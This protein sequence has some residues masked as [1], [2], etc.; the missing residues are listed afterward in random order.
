MCRSIISGLLWLLFLVLMALPS[1]AFSEQ[2]NNVQVE[3][4]VM[5]GEADGQRLLLDVY[6]PAESKK[7]LPAIVLVH[8]GGW[9][10][11]D[12]RDFHDVAMTLSESGYVC[13]SVNYRLVTNAGNKYPAQ[14]DDVQRAVRWIRANADKYGVDPNHIGALGASAGGHLV[15]LLGTMD[16]RINSDPALARYS[17]R[18]TCVVDMFGPV[19]LTVRF[20]V[21]PGADIEGFVVNLIGKAH[22]IAPGAY[23]NASPLFHINKKTVPFLIFHGTADPF[24]P[25]VQSQRFYNE[26]HKAHIEATFIEFDGEGHGFSRKENINRFFIETLAFFNR[27]L[28]G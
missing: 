16:T 10:G 1:S 15:S 6:R 22:V 24:V 27:H 9:S 7:V 25:I 20:P 8:G 21:L 3:S 26:L 12:K 5:Y 19:D 23:R 2:S 14:L 13:F 4:D 18:V 17:S 28:K 11:G